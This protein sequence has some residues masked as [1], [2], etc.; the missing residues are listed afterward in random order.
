[1]GSATTTDERIDSDEKLTADDATGLLLEDASPDVDAS[2]D[3][4]ASGDQQQLVD[5]L[6][7]QK[8]TLRVPERLLLVAASNWLKDDD[9]VGSSSKTFGGM[10]YQVACQRMLQRAL[11]E[12]S[13]QAKDRAIAWAASELKPN[14]DPLDGIPPVPQQD[15]R[16]VTV[17]LS[18]RAYT[19]A[20][21]LGLQ[22]GGSLSI[23]KIC[24][25][26]LCEELRQKRHQA[27]EVL[28]E[29]IEKLESDSEDL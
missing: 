3:E 17:K 23:P 21:Q 14:D 8:L 7:P 27:I 1:M 12:R 18:H 5:E 26:L 28:T 20:Q 15:L 16:N 11:L 10:K 13:D 25:P 29:A 2:L 24:E 22:F 6:P 19:I 9:E 4:E